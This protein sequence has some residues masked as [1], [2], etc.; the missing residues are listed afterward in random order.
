[1]PAERVRV[2]RAAEILGV[3]IRTV[4]SLAQRGTIPAARVGGVWTFDEQKL[5]AWLSQREI[6]QCLKG[7]VEACP[8]GA[9]GAGMS[10]GS[11]RPSKGGS[12]AKAY[13]QAMSRLRSAKRS[14]SVPA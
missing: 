13:E 3:T 2:T 10:S 6:E 14:A 12:T 8:K 4:Q 11:A 1:M 7:E 9:T 5:R